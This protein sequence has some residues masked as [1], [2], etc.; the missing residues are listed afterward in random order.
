MPKKSEFHSVE[1]F[2]KVRDKHAAILAGKSPEE[3]IAFFSTSPTHRL[4]KASSRR[5][6]SGAL[7]S[8]RMS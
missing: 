8:K 3:V 1:F 4:A 2:R 5:G 7:G 6:K